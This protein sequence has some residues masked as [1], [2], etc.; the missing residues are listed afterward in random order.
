MKTAMQELIEKME[1][2]KSQK[3]NLI[4]W[5]LIIKVY[6]LERKEKDIMLNFYMWMR[7]NEKAEKYIDYSDEDMLNEYLK[8]TI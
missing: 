5:L 8:Q 7:M 6:G 1:D 4:D 3:L 2:A